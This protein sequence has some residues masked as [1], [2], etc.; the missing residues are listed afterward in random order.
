ME[1]DLEADIK[2]LGLT[3]SQLE[4]KAQERDS[5]RTLVVEGYYA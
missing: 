5:W 3:W 4:R 1:T 2:R